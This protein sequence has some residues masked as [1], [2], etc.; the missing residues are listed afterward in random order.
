MGQKRVIYVYGESD[1]FSYIWVFNG[2][3]K[4]SCSWNSIYNLLYC[5][6]VGP[7]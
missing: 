3:N 5:L 1:S 2:I 7:V 4:E 6:F